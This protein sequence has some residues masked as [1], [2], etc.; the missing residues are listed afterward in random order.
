M[1]SN[2]DLQGTSGEQGRYVDRKAS[3]VHSSVVNGLSELLTV[4]HTSEAIEEWLQVMECTGTL[5]K[6]GKTERRG[7]LCTG[8]IRDKNHAFEAPDGDNLCAAR[9]ATS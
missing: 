9:H 5:F 2:D 3:L 8:C 4:R 1:G 6:D 7:I